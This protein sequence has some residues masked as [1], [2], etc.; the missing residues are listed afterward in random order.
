MEVILWGWGVGGDET[1]PPRV[2]RERDRGPW[3]KKNTPRRA[4][5][6][7]HPNPN[8]LLPF[9]QGLRT[10]ICG[11]PDMGKVCT[12]KHAPGFVAAAP[13]LAAAGVDR[14]LV[15]APGDPVTVHAWA[16]SVL[17]K[18]GPTPVTAMADKAGDFARLLGVDAPA[19]SP[20]PTHRWSAL[21]EDGILLRLH[22]EESPASVTST[23]GER[24]VAT[25][26]EFFGK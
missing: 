12:E 15:V 1:R 6:A 3:E 9:S 21:V 8:P 24:M 19:G 16:A 22:V 26:G 2:A 23:S 25:A 4:P 13:A 14:V 11:V 18:G 20:T 5:R 17:G 7:P 10:A